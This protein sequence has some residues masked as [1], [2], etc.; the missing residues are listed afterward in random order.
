MLAALLL[1]LLLPPLPLLLVLLLLLLPLL[2]LPLLLLPLLLLLYCTISTSIMT[3]IMDVKDAG[4]LG[5]RA[6]DARMLAPTTLGDVRDAGNVEGHPDARRQW[7][8]RDVGM[9]ARPKMAG[10]LGTLG[11]PGTHAS[12]ARAAEESRTGLRKVSRV[13]LTGSR[14]KLWYLLEK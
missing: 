3:A 10:T 7:M 6:E 1:L 13:Q 2:L 9:P 4:M 11:M 8:A 5:R 14:S 12:Q